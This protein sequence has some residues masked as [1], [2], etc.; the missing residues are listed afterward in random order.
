MPINCQ[1]ALRDLERVPN[2]TRVGCYRLNAA[3]FKAGVEESARRLR[4]ALAAVLRRK[5]RGAAC[6]L[7]RCQSTGFPLRSPNATGAPGFQSNSN[8][9]CD[10]A[11]AGAGQGGA[12]RHGG[13]FVGR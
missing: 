5:V 4:G 12:S 7:E 6:E 10:P 3:P 2:E 1:A 8:S 11:G 9:N 13:L